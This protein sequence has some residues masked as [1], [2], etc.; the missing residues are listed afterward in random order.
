MA[1]LEET[2]ME[3]VRKERITNKEIEMEKIRSLKEELDKI[4]DDEI[5]KD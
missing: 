3:K 5:Y 4:P 2:A 1:E